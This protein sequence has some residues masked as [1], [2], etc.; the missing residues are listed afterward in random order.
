[1]VTVS[2]PRHLPEPRGFCCNGPVTLLQTL[3]L[4]ALIGLAGRPIGVAFPGLGHGV[5][6]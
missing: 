4:F 5:A 3:P 6:G 2:W 1:M